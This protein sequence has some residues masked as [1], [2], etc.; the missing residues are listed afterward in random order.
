M[1]NMFNKRQLDALKKIGNFFLSF[2]KLL[3]SGNITKIVAALV[4]L[5]QVWGA[6]IFDTP[7]NPSGPKL[8]MSKFVLT[9][10]D[11]FNAGTF[12]KTYWSGHYCWGDNGTWPRDTAFWNRGQV[13]FRGGNLVIS[14]SYL[15]NGP[16]GPEGPSGP[17]YYSYG[18]DTNPLTDG[19]TKPGFE[20]LYGY[21]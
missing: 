21:F 10:S 12:N 5:A 2:P 6:L 16:V 7:A 18:M 20:Q 14:A 17:A 1:A 11:E 15:E 13:S 4:V 8:D 3:F 19:P 9:W